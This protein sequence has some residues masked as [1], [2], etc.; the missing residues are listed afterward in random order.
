MK[1]IVMGAT[2]GIGLEVAKILNGQG[3]E[4]GIAG[5]R[6]E[7]LKAIKESLS[8]V[9]AYMPIDIT[10]ADAPEKLESLIEQLGGVDLYF[11]SS[12]IGYQNKE[13][14]PSIELKTIETNC[15]GLTR[16]INTVFQYFCQENRKGQIA[17]ITSIARTKGIGLAPSY[18]ATKRFQSTYVQALAQLA[19]TRKADISF[20]EIR[21][22]FVDTALLK[23]KY[24][25]LLKPEAVAQK[26]VKAIHHR[27]R[28]VTIDWKYR[29]L[30][31]GWEMIPNWL[32]ERWDLS[33]HTK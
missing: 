29:L 22:G 32:W 2:S 25:M 15:S 21:P 17:V 24:P 8:N 20:T 26:I 23:H 6:E 4:L 7:N 18:S 16:V 5:R 31:F 14:D 19:T 33:K 12:G 11:H 28:V 13:L 3:Y 30:V 9:K 1:A 27:K 10:A